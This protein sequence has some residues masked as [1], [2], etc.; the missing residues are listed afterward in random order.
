M[1]LAEYLRNKNKT[2]FLIQC[3]MKMVNKFVFDIANWLNKSTRMGG[4][5]EQ[6]KSNK[7]RLDSIPQYTA[8]RETCQMIFPSQGPY[9]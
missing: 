9:K 5:G 4:G 8:P 7:A 1:F 2:C 6:R 3:L